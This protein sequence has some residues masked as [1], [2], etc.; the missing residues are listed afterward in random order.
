M[1][2]TRAFAI[3]ALVIVNALWGLSFPTVKALNWQLDQHFNDF[4]N[5]EALV[6]RL[7]AATWIIASRFA[8]AF[9]LFFA[10]LYPI[11]S[12]A[13]PRDWLAGSVI[14]FAF[15]LGLI[16]QTIGL[17]TIPASR[18][19]FLTSLSVVFTPIFFALLHRRRPSAMVLCGAG[20]SVIGVSVLTGAFIIDSNGLRPAPDMFSRWTIGDS[21][22]TLATIFF[23]GQIL[24]IDWFSKI[25]NPAAFTPGMFLTVS[26]LAFVVFA[27]SV[28]CFG[29][30][31]PSIE[32]AKLFLKPSCSTMVL[33]LA[34][35]PSLLAF[36]LMNTFQPKVT[37][38]Q[39]AV[40]YTLEP[41]FV[42]L[43]AMF[44]PGLFSTYLGLPMT[45]E[46][47]TLPIISGGLLI[48]TANLFA[49]WP[50]NDKSKPAA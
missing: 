13:T 43:S 36:S 15:L 39:A 7:S 28:L 41:V 23:A 35:L 29:R 18:S 24:A 2:K 17:A 38:V 32:F 42:T 34:V 31:V 19:G 45:N 37:A 48:L 50:T 26:L 12:K 44:L 4:T 5:T 11:V 47:L 1:I 20:L 8:L 21:L 9:V 14:G 16:L 27:V 22:T 40:I 49:L 6:F 25:A 46:V 33:G 10:V 3:F 30:E